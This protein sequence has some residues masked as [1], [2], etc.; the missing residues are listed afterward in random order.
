MYLQVNLSPTEC[1]QISGFRLENF[2]F[3]VI[4]RIWNFFSLLMSHMLYPMVVSDFRYV[5]E[6]VLG[7]PLSLNPPINCTFMVTVYEFR[8]YFTFTLTSTLADMIVD[9]I[10]KT[11]IETIFEIISSRLTL[12]RPIG[13][14]PHA[15]VAQKIADQ[16][17]LIANSEKI[18]NFFI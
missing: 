9:F 14:P 17:W 15:L 18:G 13:L 8:S 16:R 2:V 4:S 3:F 7:C 11:I 10:F 6:K 12:S 1:S 5:S